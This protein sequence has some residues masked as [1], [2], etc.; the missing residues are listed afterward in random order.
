MSVF[1]IYLLIDHYH[2]YQPINVP[3]AVAQACLMDYPPR[4]HSADWWVPTSANAA[5]TNSL[6]CIP[7]H[8]GA[9]DS[10]FLVTHPMTDQRCAGLSS[11]SIIYQNLLLK[12]S[13]NKTQH[14]QQFC[15][16]NFS[17]YKFCA[18]PTAYLK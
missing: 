12:L 1:Y 6:T 16:K 2:N 4:E 9:R 10:K 18:K 5:G 15:F 3:I 14:Y 8:G 17:Y 13:Y 7:K 11:S